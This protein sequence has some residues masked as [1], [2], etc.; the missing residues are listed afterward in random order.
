M[1]TFDDPEIVIV[2]EKSLVTS[3]NVDS[4]RTE[5]EKVC[6]V[7]GVTT[8]FESEDS[9]N[10]FCFPKVAFKSLVKTGLRFALVISIA[11]P[12]NSAP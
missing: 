12:T 7:N 1:Q 6:G 4:S 10:I 11:L 8:I 3:A 2:E 5:M 9:T